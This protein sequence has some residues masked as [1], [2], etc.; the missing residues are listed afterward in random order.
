MRSY[1]YADLIV[2]PSRWEGLSL[3]LLEAMATERTVVAFNVVG[4][5]D[6]LSDGAGLLVSPESVSELATQTVRC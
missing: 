6:A 2:M 5:K 3:A 1:T 4:M